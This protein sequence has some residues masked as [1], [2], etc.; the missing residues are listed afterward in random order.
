MDN[1]MLGMKELYDCQLKAVFQINING[2]TI[3]PGEPIAIFQSIQFGA[4]EEFKEHAAA[5]G[6]YHNQS[7]VV[8]DSTKE[9]AFNF[10]QGVF[11]KLHLALISNSNIKKTENFNVPKIENIVTNEDSEATLRYTP[12]ANTLFLY[13]SDGNRIV[14][15]SLDN[16]IVLFNNFQYEDVKAVYDFEYTGFV[17]SIIIGQ[18]LIQ[19][20]IELTAKTRLKDDKTGQTVTGIIKI[21]K[22]RLVSNL[23]MRLGR[24]L[25]PM[26]NSFKTIGYPTG[27]RGSE[28]VMEFTI[29]NDDIDSDI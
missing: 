20:Y 29:L 14:D 25:P 22:L 10:T 7:K 12:I 21:P 28:R 27:P 3:D 19:G 5:K 18:E 26:V 17:D 15:Y 1:N 2:K 24:D 8:W 16:K 9:V 6:G 23:S 4:A 13:D 11:S